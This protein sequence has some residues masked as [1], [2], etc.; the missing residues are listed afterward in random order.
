ME[1]ITMIKNLYNSA[2]KKTHITEV[3]NHRII[4]ITEVKYEARKM[5]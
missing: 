3:E 5:K 1:M 4:N 2:L